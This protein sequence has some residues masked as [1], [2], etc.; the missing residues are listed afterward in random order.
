[1]FFRRATIFTSKTM[2]RLVFRCCS[3]FRATCV[4]K[5][6]KKKLPR[7]WKYIKILTVP[8]EHRLSFRHS[9]L[10]ADL[11]LANAHPKQEIKRTLYYDKVRCSLTSALPRRSYFD[12]HV[13]PLREKRCAST[14]IIW[15]MI[16][17][18]IALSLSLNYIPQNT[19]SRNLLQIDN[20]NLPLQLARLS[21]PVWCK[22]QACL[23]QYPNEITLNT[24]QSHYSS[25]S[26]YKGGTKRFSCD[27]E[28]LERIV[29][30]DLLSSGITR[31]NTRRIARA[32]F[33][34]IRSKILTK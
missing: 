26:K 4:E 5:S 2:A 9:R 31:A 30:I 32:K 17:F 19:I 3:I 13:M 6:S 23:V 16:H 10:K 8:V 22:S 18:C 21:Q 28:A 7:I 14:Q 25:C 12:H 29:T 34:L 11:R 24:S 27:Q 33:H 1:M 20:F 15:K